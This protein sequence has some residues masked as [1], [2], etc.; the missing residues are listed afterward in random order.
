M[1]NVYI[2]RAAELYGITYT[3]PIYE[4]AIEVLNNEQARYN[5]LNVLEVRNYQALKILCKCFFLFSC[6]V[7]FT[8]K[9]ALRLT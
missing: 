7:H 5:I 3:R 4:K 8:C 6:A 2:K 9:C 1:F